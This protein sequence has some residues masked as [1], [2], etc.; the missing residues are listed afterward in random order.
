M[1]KK[2][3]F[4]FALIFTALLSSCS[5]VIPKT[6][7]VAPKY[8]YELVYQSAYPSTLEPG[9]VTNIWIEV[10]NTGNQ[11]WKSYGNNIVR[12]G[13]GSSFG[14]AN[15]KRDYT[16]EFAN[17]DWLSANRPTNISF[18]EVRP[19]ETTKFQFN[20]KAPTNPGVYKAYFTPV[21]DGSQWMK[22]IGIYWQITVRGSNQISL[23][24]SAQIAYQT[25]ELADNF[26]PS[27]VKIICKVSEYFWNQGS[28]TIFHNS[29]GNPDLPEYYIMTNLHVVETNNGSRP[30]CDIKIIPDYKN[31][32]NYFIFE[33]EGYRY[34]EGFDFAIL[35]P[36]I[37]S[38]RINA[39]SFNILARYAK[40]DREITKNTV[41][42][43]DVG[44][45][46][47]VLGYPENGDFSITE[48]YVA[49][50]EFYQ[51]SKYID[52]TALLRHGNSGGLAINSYGQ[53]LG[54]PTFLKANNIGMILDTSYL[55][56]K[57]LN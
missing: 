27:V 5:F 7:A 11:I 37:N 6:E 1:F 14:N 12:L 2:G 10:K 4:I 18:S 49:G 15:Q 24:N 30:K 57:I 16:S 50:Y 29:S 48:G 25:S 35:E 33:S 41:I 55:M 26:A 28:G 40:E 36:K 3:L 51:G 22:D 20:I 47:L 53:I 9:S 56:G 32:D 52:T 21:V 43:E 13:S 39:G 8:D 17:Y 23:G 45:K 31:K 54:I 44:E 42:K 34:Y 19:G 46:M 38:S